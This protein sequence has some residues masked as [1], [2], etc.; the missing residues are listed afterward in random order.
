MARKG[1]VDRGL[2]S[3]LNAE[4]KTVWWVRLYHHGKEERFGSYPTKTEA[5][6]FYNKAK[7]EQR[8]GRF[9]P[10]TYQRSTAKLISTLLEEYL[11]TTYGKRNQ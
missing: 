2:L 10:E 11:A 7:N 4:G 5:R 6:A 9:F 3:K 1:R 8:E